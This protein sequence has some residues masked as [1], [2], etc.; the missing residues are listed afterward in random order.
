MALL[1]GTLIAGGRRPRARKSKRGEAT[2]RQAVADPSVGDVQS[3]GLDRG[4]YNFSAGPACLPEEV[5]ARAQNELLSWNGSG[6]SVLEVSHRGDEYSYIHQ[7]AKDDLTELLGIPNN[8]RVLF[9]QGGA[10]TQFACVPLNLAKPEDVSDYIITGS[11]GVKAEKEALRYCST[12]IAATDEDNN[13]TGIPKP[14]EWNL[15]SNPSYVHI[16]HNETIQGVEFKGTPDVGNR[17]LVADMSSN[18]LSKPINISDYG[19]IYAGAQKN[20]GPSGVTIVIVREDLLGKEQLSTPTMLDWQVMA[21][22]DSLHN[23]PPCFAV[24]MCSLVFEHLKQRGG[25]A[26]VEQ[27]N[28]ERAQ[29]LYQAV[30]KSGGFYQC[31]QDP[32]VRSNMNIPFTI[33]DAELEKKF[34]KEAAERNMVQLKGHRSVGGMRASIYNAMPTAGINKLIAFMDEF[35]KANA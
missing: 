15:S 2:R 32:E 3:G 34:I 27:D 28:I 14:S 9:M 19:V 10:S 21:E 5:L 13:F 29:R 1:S 18:F 25:L 12:N 11:W 22:S 24:Y 35:Q 30:D 6:M 7:K 33:G 4:V 17:T 20:V 26:K 8:Y 23:T 16:C 31:P